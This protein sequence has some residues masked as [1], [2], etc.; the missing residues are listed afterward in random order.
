MNV[1]VASKIPRERDRLARMLGGAGHSVQGCGT[2]AEVEAAMRGAAPEVAIVC[3]V[4]TDWLQ[5]LAQ[6]DRHIYTIAALTELSGRK[7]QE[8]WDLGV[9][10]V[11]RRAA[12]AEEVLGRVGAVTRIKGWIESMGA[13]FAADAPFDVRRLAV[14]RELGNLLAEEYGGMTGATL[15]QRPS[16]KLPA[17]LYA[18]EVTLTLAA[19]SVEMTLGVGIEEASAGP[20]A[21]M[22]FGEAVPPEV[23]ADAMREFANSAGGAF[24]RS[25]LNEDQSFSLGLPQDSM[26][27]SPPEGPGWLL[28]GGGIRLIVWLIARKDQPRRVTAAN[29]EEGMVLAQAVRNGAGQLLVAAGSVLTQRTVARL[30]EMVGPTALVEV[31]S[32]A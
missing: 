11:M 6:S 13:D 16:K 8:A 7:V 29:L 9:D 1:L 20:F 10:D 3:H 24:K 5:P 25:A 17:P 15:E 23:M 32:A 19:E 14:V 12:S 26:L 27:M 28:A 18:A 4:A 31:A 21:S 2:P 30:I 22:L